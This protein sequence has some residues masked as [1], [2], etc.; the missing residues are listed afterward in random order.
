[1]RLEFAG[2]SKSFAGVKAVDGV[3]FAVQPGS[4]H[5]L[6]GEN[7]AGKSTLL[8]MLS[9][10]LRPDS[11]Q[12]LLDG[13]PQR[14]RGPADALGAGIAVI[15]QELQLMP[16]QSAAENIFVGHLPSR[17][18]LIR[19]RAMN[20]RAAELLARL[21]E[22]FDPRTRMGDLPIGVRQV[23]EIAKALAHE[24]SVI[25]FDEPTSS[26]SSR[27]TERLFAV[28]DQLRSDGKTILYVS[29]RMNEIFRLCDSGTVLRDGKWVTT[30]ESLRSVTQDMLVQ[31]M[32]GRE[33]SNIYGYRSRP[34]GKER[35]VAKGIAGPGL[36]APV[37]LTVR[38]GEIVGFFGL[39]G[40]GRTELMK[41]LAGAVRRSAGTVELDGES[42]AG[43]GSVEAVRRG[44]IYCPEDRKKEG[45]VA[46]RSVA[47]NTNLSVRRLF[48]PER[49]F[50]SG[51][52][53]IANAEHFRQALGI[54]TS[55]I[56]K[57]IG[58][59]SGGNQ[60]KVILGRALSEKP[61]AILLDEPTRG[62]DVGAKSE[63]YNIIYKLAESGVAICIVSSEL[64]EVL[65][66]CDR[67]L[68]MR[69]GRLVGET[70]RD[71]ATQENLLA[72][73]LPTNA[74][75]ETLQPATT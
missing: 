12:L 29:H 61:R 62:I 17:F 57:R 9:G 72:L 3:S 37:D 25:A 15:Q 54:R 14:F 53:E 40:A 13:R 75:S 27:E 2:I 74:V 31:R 56:H 28:I 23:T 49:A 55:S 45:I 41:L 36:K 48:S 24:A 7:G 50:I 18:G 67:I 64:P 4:V 43:R 66:V 26:L 60:Q 69:E 33:I 39:V 21:G 59:L 73:A 71:D 52:R 70:S 16:D 5:A 8:K 58:L 10:A 63:I 42:L 35:L 68:I 19:R 44:L 11:G 65:G 20:E 30:Y 34:L 6:L 32:V 38:R 51:Q 22:H 46:I 47:E 1:M